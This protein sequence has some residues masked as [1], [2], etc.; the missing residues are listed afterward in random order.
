MAT[1]RDPPHGKQR[2]KADFE[3]KNAICRLVEEGTG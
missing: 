2:I 3:G 1:D